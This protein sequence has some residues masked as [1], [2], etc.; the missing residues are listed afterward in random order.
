MVRPHAFEALG[1]ALLGLLL[2]LRLTDGSMRSLVQG[3]YLPLLVATALVLLAFAAITA[4]QAMRSSARWQPALGPGMLLSALLIGGP[5]IAGFALRPAPLGS[6]SLDAATNGDRP[7]SASAASGEPAQRNL[8]QWAYAFSNLPQAE[9]LGEPVDLIGFVY[10][11][12]DGQAADRFAV[13]RFVVA[14]CV[15]DAAGYTLPVQ[16]S[17]AGALKQDSWVHIRG[18]IAS[19]GDGTLLVQAASVDVVNAP[20]NP[21]IYP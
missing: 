6:A 18:S 2:T 12:K 4:V 1:A 11:G 8:Y 13:A 19:S 20:A 15:A 3:W 21:Y 14:C 5:I 7:F 9:L 16:W 17:G 10:H